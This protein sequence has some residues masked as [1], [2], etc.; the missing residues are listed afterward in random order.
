MSHEQKKMEKILS[1]ENQKIFKKKYMKKTFP[2][3]GRG[4]K[5]YATDPLNWKIPCKYYKGFVVQGKQIFLNKN[6]LK[7]GEY[8]IQ[9]NSFL[10]SEIFFGH[11]LLNTVFFLFIANTFSGSPIFEWNIFSR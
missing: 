5:N 3:N 7:N 1:P 6:N 10:F 9:Y 8:I 2:K 11:A 4:P